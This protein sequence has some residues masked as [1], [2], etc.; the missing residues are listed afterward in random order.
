MDMSSKLAEIRRHWLDVER[1][2][3][4]VAGDVDWLIEQAGE[5]ERLRINLRDYRQKHPCSHEVMCWADEVA[6]KALA[7]D[8]CR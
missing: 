7:R 6:S 2:P 8:K 1:S 4:L 3:R 5:V